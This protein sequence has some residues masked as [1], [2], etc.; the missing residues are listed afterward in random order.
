MQ[1][2]FNDCI[3]ATI[4]WKSFLLALKQKDW[5]ESVCAAQLILNTLLVPQ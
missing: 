2:I 3:A 4:E 5:N 1:I